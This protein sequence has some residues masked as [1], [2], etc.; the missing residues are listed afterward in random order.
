MIEV[1]EAKSKA[2]RKYEIFPNVIL[3]ETATSFYLLG[4]L[5]SDGHIIDSP[6]SLA[7]GISSNDKDWLED[8]RNLICP[9]KPIYNHKDNCFT[10]EF[11]HAECMNWLI[12]YGCTPRKS[13]TIRLE[14]PI[15]E[16]FIPDFIR[17]LVDGDGSV[18]CVKYKKV[19]PNG[20]TYWYHKVSTYICSASKEFIDDL[21]RLI[22][23][24]FNALICPCKTKASII[25][26]KPII[27]TVEF[28]YRLAFNDQNA[29]KFLQ[30]IYYPGHE[31]SLNRKREKAQNILETISFPYSG[32]KWEKMVNVKQGA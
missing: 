25:R 6:R 28:N 26:G 23:S 7:I 5:M 18:N 22:P 11:S 32:K 27:P 15:P 19:K 29:L 14:K 2:H 9:D 31:L 13:L 16:T 21:Y 10:F 30:W 12:S 4:A 3:D 24:E 8:I 20:K 1:S 17:G